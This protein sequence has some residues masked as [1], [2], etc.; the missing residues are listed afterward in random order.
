MSNIAREVTAQI[1]VILREDPQNIVPKARL[2]HDLGADSLDA[3][4]L[5]MAIEDRFGID[6][7]DEDAEGLRTVG[8]LIEYVELAI[9]I[10]QRLK[11]ERNGAGARAPR[12][13]RADG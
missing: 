7:P 4:A 13:L 2:A 3:V 1:A 8:Q 5:V 9:A 10:R 6:I 12:D 11:E